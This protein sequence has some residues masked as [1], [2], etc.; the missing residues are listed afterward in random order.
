MP[1]GEVH[2]RFWVANA[3][4]MVPELVTCDLTVRP[5]LDFDEFL[6]IYDGFY[7]CP[8]PPGAAKRP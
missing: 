2:G 6:E 8:R 5:T 4:H 1:S 7:L 3:T